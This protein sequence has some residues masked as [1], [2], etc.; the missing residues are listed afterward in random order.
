LVRTFN[1]LDAQQ[2][3]RCRS[4]AT[5][6]CPCTLGRRR[7]PTPNPRLALRAGRR[8]KSSLRAG[9]HRY[10]IPTGS[11]AGSSPLFF[12]VV[13]GLGLTDT[14]APPESLIYLHHP[15]LITAFP[16]VLPWLAGMILL[17][18]HSIPARASRRPALIRRPATDC[19]RA[20]FS[21]F[22]PLFRTPQSCCGRPFP[23]LHPNALNEF[24]VRA[25][26]MTNSVSLRRHGHGRP[27]ARCLGEDFF[28]LLFPPPPPPFSS[29][30]GQK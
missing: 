13:A 28:S 21:S 16:P 29:L 2:R 7:R 22:C 4:A 17:Q 15:R 20:S 24:P 25:G 30:L 26:Q 12:Q 6:D 23:P 18:E 3:P 19:R 27:A 11:L 1:H 5:T 14:V 10:L 9:V 8:I